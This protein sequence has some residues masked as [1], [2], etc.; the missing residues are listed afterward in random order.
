MILL[1]FSGDLG[2]VCRTK[3]FELVEDEQAVVASGLGRFPGRPCATRL[4]L[5][6]ASTITGLADNLTSF[7]KNIETPSKPL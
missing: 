2:C 7:A 1:T 3:A 5:F 4:E 6:R